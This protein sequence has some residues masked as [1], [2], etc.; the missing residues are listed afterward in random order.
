M[1]NKNLLNT[2]KESGMLYF[3]LVSLISSDILLSVDDCDNSIKKLQE[4]DEMIPSSNL[5][6]D[7]KEKIHNFCVEGI[8]ICETD[9]NNLLSAETDE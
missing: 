7:E 5:N 3:Y 8:N 4:L 2:L 1:E 6:N 9:R